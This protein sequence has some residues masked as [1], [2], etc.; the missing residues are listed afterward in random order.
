MVIPL[1]YYYRCRLFTNPIPTNYYYHSTNTQ[2]ELILI[3][4]SITYIPDSRQYYKLIKDLGGFKK[5]DLSAAPKITMVEIDDDRILG[6]E[7]AVG[8]IVI[9]SVITHD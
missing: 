3:L 4:I 8:G 9:N 2:L 5:F 6:Q 1:K 7:A